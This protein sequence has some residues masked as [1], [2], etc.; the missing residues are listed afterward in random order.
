MSV[1]VCVCYV[2]VYECMRAYVSM[3]MSI[4]G[5]VGEFMCVREYVFGCRCGYVYAYVLFTCMFLW[6]CVYM[7][8]CVCMYVCLWMYAC[9][10]LYEYMCVCMCVHVF[11][12]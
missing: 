4:Y 3:S 10:G 8:L 5:F 11:M 6:V 2:R 12:Y 9:N 1:W 7:Y